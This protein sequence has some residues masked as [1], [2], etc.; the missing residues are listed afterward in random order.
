MI[1]LS[2]LPKN[3]QN[4]LFDFY[5]FLLSKYGKEEN[6]K[7]TTDESRMDIMDAFFDKYELDL[8]NYSFNRDE[9]YDR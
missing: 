4:E 9:I 3:A 1:N 5:Q 7:A 2:V 6:E 8:N